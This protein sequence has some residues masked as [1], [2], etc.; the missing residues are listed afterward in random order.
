MKK[1]L[2][3]ISAVLWVVLCPAFVKALAVEIIPSAHKVQQWDFTYFDLKTHNDL[4]AKNSFLVSI[5][6]PY[7][8]WKMPGDVLLVL[9]DGETKTSK[10]IFRPTKEGKFD[11]KVRVTPFSNP[12]FFVE[13]DFSLEV[14]GGIGLKNLKTA[15]AG[16]SLKVSMDIMSLEERRVIVNMEVLD[17]EGMVVTS[18]ERPVTIK[19][20]QN[21]QETISLDGVLAGNYKFRAFVGDKMVEKNFENEAFSNIIREYD[22]SPGILRDE[23][24]IIIRNEGNIIE[25]FVVKENVGTNELTGFVT[26]PTDCMTTPDSKD[27]DFGITGLVPG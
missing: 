10:I 14:L 18:S 15:V 1:V 4:G 19:G 24:V 8:Q 2:F 22:N 20:T 27:C 16:Q 5:E 7:L 17:S 23:V 9:N 11:Y 25:N 21:I 12:D 3:L 26:K 13:K 6:G